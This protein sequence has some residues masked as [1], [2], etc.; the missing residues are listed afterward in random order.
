M[1]L[2]QLSPAALTNA[3]LDYSRRWNQGS[4]DLPSIS[5]VF[6]WERRILEEPETTWLVFQDIVRECPDDD[7]TLEQVWYRLELPLSRH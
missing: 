4:T 6:E 1:E 2:Q 5:P 7:D 3:Y